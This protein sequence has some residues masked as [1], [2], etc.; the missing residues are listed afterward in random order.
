[1][2]EAQGFPA[3]SGQPC[4]HIGVNASEARQYR[5]MSLVSPN[6]KYRPEIDGLCAIS[7]PLVSLHQLGF[8]YITAG[9][10]GVEVFFV[11]PGTSIVKE[12]VQ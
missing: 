5:R 8:L 7:V 1:M 9:H 12:V 4:Q 6:S 10:I 3:S 2:N 11:I